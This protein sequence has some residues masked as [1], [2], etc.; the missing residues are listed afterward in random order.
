[1][2]RIDRAGIRGIREIR[3]ISC[4]MSDGTN[5]QEGVILSSP[6]F[7]GRRSNPVLIER[8]CHAAFRRLAMTREDIG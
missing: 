4:C 3:V 1:M 2:D 5:Q 8:D 7:G 6:P